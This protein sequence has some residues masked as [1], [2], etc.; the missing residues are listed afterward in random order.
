MDDWRDFKI[1]AL[2]TWLAVFEQ[3]L[4][5]PQHISPTGVESRLLRTERTSTSP[6]RCHH[7]KM[8]SRQPFQCRA[9]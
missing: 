8:Q 4:L 9:V 2:L 6:C 5:A 3:L 1:E 7:G